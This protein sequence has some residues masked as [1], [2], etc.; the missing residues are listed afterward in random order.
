MLDPNQL[1][2]SFNE[3][4]EDLPAW[5]PDGIISVDL[6]MLDELGLLHQDDDE[7]ESEDDEQF[8]HYF[9]VIETDD[10]VTLFNHQ[11]AVWIV[12]QM[13]DE[14]P[15]TV[16]LI[17]LITNDV[18]SLELAFATSGVYNTPK[19]VLKVLRHYLTEVIDTESV[20]SSIDQG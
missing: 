12:P 11:F 7:S 3:F 17:S 15:V 6:K 9:H 1:E 5:I 19:F 10:K 8:P 14:T 4:I 18:P 16:T 20:I 2:D 13:M